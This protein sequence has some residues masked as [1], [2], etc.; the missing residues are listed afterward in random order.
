MRLRHGNRPVQ[1]FAPRCPNHAL[2]N[3]IRIGSVADKIA[4]AVHGVRLAPLDIR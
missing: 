1:A 4:Q 3:G 2:A